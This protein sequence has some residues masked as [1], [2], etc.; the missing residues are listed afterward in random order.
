MEASWVSWSMLPWAEDTYGSEPMNKKDG[1]SQ[2]SVADEKK[3]V[4]QKGFIEG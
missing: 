2:K 3:E 1:I 4:R